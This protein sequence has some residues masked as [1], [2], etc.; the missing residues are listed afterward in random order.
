MDR[1]QLCKHGNGRGGLVSVASKKSPT[2]CFL[3]RRSGTKFTIKPA[4]TI[5]AIRTRIRPNEAT[6]MVLASR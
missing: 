5:A 3:T 2:P 6:K 1:N 4:E